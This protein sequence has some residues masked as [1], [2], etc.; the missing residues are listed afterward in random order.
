MTEAISNVQK[1]VPN[2]L[3]EEVFIKNKAFQEHITA[4]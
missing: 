4:N 2:A 3:A 1:S